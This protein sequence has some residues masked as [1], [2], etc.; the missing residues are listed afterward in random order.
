MCDKYDVYF[1]NAYIV[2]NGDLETI[3][4]KIKSS[5]IE[6]IV[7]K[8]AKK[9]GFKDDVRYM[10]KFSIHTGKRNPYGFEE[11]EPI[12]WDEI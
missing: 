6:N 8:D 4:E 5:E 7:I 2:E 11:T 10:Y 3:A 9:R 12:E 1:D